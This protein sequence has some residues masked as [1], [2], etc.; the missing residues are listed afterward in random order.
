VHEPQGKQN[1]G[2]RKAMWLSKDPVKYH[3][4]ALFLSCSH[5]RL[6]RQLLVNKLA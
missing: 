3:S 4:N 6:C 2:E 5:Q 1:S